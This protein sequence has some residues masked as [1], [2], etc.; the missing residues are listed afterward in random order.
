MPCVCFPQCLQLFQQEYCGFLHRPVIARIVATGDESF[1]FRGVMRRM[2]QI[3]HSQQQEEMRVS[4]CGGVCFRRLRH[5][6]FVK[7][8]SQR[9]R[10]LVVQGM[11][12]DDA[13]RVSNRG[14]VGKGRSGRQRRFLFHWYVAHG[15]RDLRGV[16]RRSREPAAFYR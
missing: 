15:Q 4:K 12:S 6:P 5:F 8:A 13:L 1:G 3:I 7:P 2:K 16:L 14:W 9:E 10:E 11:L